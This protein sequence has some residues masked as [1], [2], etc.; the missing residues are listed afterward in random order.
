MIH[1]FTLVK[2]AFLA[3]CCRSCIFF[4]NPLWLRRLW[5]SQMQVTSVL[6]FLWTGYLL[7]AKGR[8]WK[9]WDRYLKKK[10]KNLK[11]YCSSWELL[12][13]LFVCFRFVLNDPHLSHSQPS[14]ERSSECRGPCPPSSTHLL[15]I[16]YSRGKH[17]SRFLQ[18][19]SGRQ[20][21]TSLTPLVALGCIVMQMWI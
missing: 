7:H 8:F 2:K 9:N 13:S 16:P 19:L 21:E 17:S 5:F 3:L 18:L 15:P 10:K 4:F 6:L 12:Y 11:S 20:R 1:S 14:K